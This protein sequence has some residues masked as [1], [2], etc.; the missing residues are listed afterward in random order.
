MFDSGT[1]VNNYHIID[2]GASG[3]TNLTNPASGGDRLSL[4]LWFSVRY[5]NQFN[6]LFPSLQKRLKT[7]P[8]S[9]GGASVSSQNIRLRL[10]RV[11][12]IDPH[13]LISWTTGSF[14]L[15]S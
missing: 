3:S 9:G 1:A 10:L 4:Y 2:V 7:P 6:H 14:D 8:N 13:S 12:S 11:Q 5:L 15:L